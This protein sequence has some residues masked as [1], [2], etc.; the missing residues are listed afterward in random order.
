MGQAPD[1]GW[2]HVR[3]V[4]TGS[5]FVSMGVGKTVSTWGFV[6]TGEMEQD[7][8]ALQPLINFVEI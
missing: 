7:I 4:M 8:V 3:H 1:P 6:P 2:G 5:F